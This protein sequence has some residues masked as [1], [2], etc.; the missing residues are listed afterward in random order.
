MFIE[1]LVFVE[2]FEE[3]ETFPDLFKFFSA[4]LKT[5]Y[6]SGLIWL[7]KIINLGWGNFIQIRFVCC[8]LSLGSKWYLKHL[9]KPYCLIYRVNNMTFPREEIIWHFQKKKW[10]GKYLFVVLL[11]FYCVPYLWCILFIS[12]RK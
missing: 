4:M 6:K 10:F 5:S 3:I 12:K 11:E 1:L 7:S 2:I 9:S 8:A